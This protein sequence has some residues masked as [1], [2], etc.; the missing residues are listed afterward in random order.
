MKPSRAV[1]KVCLAA[2]LLALASA[3]SAR[4]Y[5]RVKPL[6]KVETGGFY[7]LGV[8]DEH[9]LIGL[10]TPVVWHDSA[11]GYWLVPGVDWTLLNAGWA[12]PAGSDRGV[13][14]LG[15][16]VALDEPIKAWLL[17]G[18]NL[19]DRKGDG[20]GVLRK[21]LAP[22]R[23]KAVK[24]ANSWTAAEGAV[25]HLSVGPMWALDTSNWRGAAVLGTTLSARF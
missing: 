11:D 7:R 21:I 13:L 14:F 20:Y 25:L 4:P 10:V 1:A 24:T 15:P 2:V 16:A 3:A 8:A 12:V 23:P 22:A 19:L 5:F 18:V 6:S 17:R 9:V